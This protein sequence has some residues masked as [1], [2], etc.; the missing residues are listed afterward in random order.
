[1][2]L[3][4]RVQRLASE[5]AGILTSRRVRAAALVLLVIALVFVLL[6]VH[7]LWHEGRVDAQRVSWPVI[8]GAGAVATAAVLAA[9]F[10][11]V[12]IMRR[13]GVRA[14]P[15]WAAMFLE[16]QLAKYI[17]G[18][19]WHYAGRAALARAE[20]VA[21][22]TVALSVTVELAASVIA[23]SVIAALALGTV[24]TAIV[25]GAAIVAF[26]AARRVRRRDVRL[27]RLSRRIAV[28]DA[29]RTARATL[30][31][32]LLYLIEWILLGIAFWLTARAFFSV[33]AD[34]MPYYVGAYATAAVVGLVAFFAPVGFGVREALIVALLR[35]RLGTT[36]AVVLATAS[37]LL[38]TLVDI[39]TAAGSAFLR[40][41]T[42]RR[43]MA[44][45]D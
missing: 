35:S 31:G 23:G 24:G 12:V 21:V 44:Q 45:H 17:P 2:A 5:R 28:A 33:P 40:R 14:R 30:D 34:Q 29:V 36:D 3:G 16:A 7:S 27:P 13:L 38:L 42:G 19:V 9:G 25:A 22:R 20:G 6:R 4:E 10:I 39:V 11:W 18:S 15:R 1:M 26:L 43:P 41:R 8:I 32:T 37:R